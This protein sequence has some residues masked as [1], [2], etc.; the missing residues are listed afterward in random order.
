[1]FEKHMLIED[2][3]FRVLY[4]YGEEN[5][6]RSTL[7]FYKAIMKG[8]KKD[9]ID[10]KPENSVEFRVRFCQILIKISMRL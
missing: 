6:T 1:M 7:D 2:G 9:T 3:K 8:F 5:F 4:H 10:F